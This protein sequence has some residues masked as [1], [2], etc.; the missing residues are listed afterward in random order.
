LP[1]FILR[2]YTAIQGAYSGTTP[3]YPSVLR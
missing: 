1:R 2:H 3:Y